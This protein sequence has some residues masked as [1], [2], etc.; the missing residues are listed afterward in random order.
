LPSCWHR[1]LYQ[2]V[3]SND[4]DEGTP[5]RQGLQQERLVAGL[6]RPNRVQRGTLR[7]G[8]LR[9]EFGDR[10]RRYEAAATDDN[11]GEFAAIHQ[12]VDCVTGNAAEQFSRFGD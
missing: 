2:S 4:V 3:R 6:T 9:N 10:R 5:G 7:G 12:S 8:G 11:A 1:S